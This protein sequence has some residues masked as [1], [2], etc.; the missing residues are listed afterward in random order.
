M[1]NLMLGLLLNQSPNT[2]G[3]WMA[4][5]LMLLLGVFGM[6]ACDGERQH[7][8]PPSIELLS[9]ATS[10]DVQIPDSVLLRVRIR[11]DQPIE[12]AILRVQ[13]ADG[14]ALQPP[15]VRWLSNRDTI[16]E[17]SVLLVD[18]M[19][20]SG[21]FQLVIQAISG[22]ETGSLFIPLQLRAVP[23]SF[24]GVV[25]FTQS[26]LSTNV[27]RCDAQGIMAPRESHL[28]LDLAQGAAVSSA[29]KVWLR[30]HTSW[31]LW[32]YHLDSLMFH[33]VYNTLADPGQ[34][35]YTFLSNGDQG[36]Y[37]SRGLGDVLR[38]SSSGALGGQFAVPFDFVPVF[39]NREQEHILVELRAR[40]PSSIRRVRIYQ[41]DF[42]GLLREFNVGGNILGAAR[43]ASDAWVMLI[44]HQNSGWGR[45]WRYHLS[46][47]QLQEE[48]PNNIDHQFKAIVAG[49]EGY[50][51]AGSSG[52]W[53]FQ[54]S[55]NVQ[56]GLWQQRFPEA[57]DNLSFDGRFGRL[58]GW[59]GTLGYIWN[60]DTGDRIACQ[61]PDSVRFSCPY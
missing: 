39:T 47:Q 30:G 36:F 33:S 56:N 10:F 52:I 57:V 15:I 13:K 26:G 50:W 40:P 4:Y 18:S 25:W 17:W 46:T 14:V 35:P 6:S 48:S 23:Q 43:I 29:R 53:N 51:L 11:S 28:V 59:K 27:Y 20:P 58:I 3:Q 5:S 16:L 54:P 55:L 12:R 31:V 37:A 2:M 24:R 19:L 34:S 8:T 21:Q 32:S 38:F 49:H 44:E 7:T 61:L 60:P 45:L 41:A 22:H 9:A 42:Q 1:F